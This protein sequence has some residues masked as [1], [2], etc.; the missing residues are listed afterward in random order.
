[1][2]YDPVPANVERYNRVYPRYLR[3]YPALKTLCGD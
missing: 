3:V 2:R 1:M